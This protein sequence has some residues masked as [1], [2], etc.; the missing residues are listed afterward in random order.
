MMSPK[1]EQVIAELEAVLRDEVLVSVKQVSLAVGRYLEAVEALASCSPLV[2]LPFHSRFI[3]RTQHFTPIL[4]SL[5]DWKK[6]LILSKL[7]P[8]MELPNPT[9]QLSLQRSAHGF[10]TTSSN[11]ESAG[12]SPVAPPLLVHQNK[13]S[14]KANVKRKRK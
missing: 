4:I 3:A 13:P 11:R 14:P 6:T 8:E 9:S 5:T 12:L 10:M 1:N 2:S 7:H